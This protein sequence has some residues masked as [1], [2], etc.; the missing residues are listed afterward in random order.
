MFLLPL[1]GAVLGSSKSG[2]CFKL[3]V[4]VV[5]ELQDT[6]RYHKVLEDSR[7]EGVIAGSGRYAGISYEQG[8]GT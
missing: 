2:A 7:R 4:E 1:H 5:G 3:I 6:V 8:E